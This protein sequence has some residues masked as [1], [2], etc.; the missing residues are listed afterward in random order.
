VVR[1]L[2]LAVDVG[3]VVN[4]DGLMNQIEGGA[5]QA[6]SWTLLES[7]A[8]DNGVVTSSGWD[9]YPILRFDRVPE[10][11]VVV[12]ER[13]GEPVL[14]A[15]EIVHGPVAAAI[16][17]GLYSA[18]GLRARTLPLTRERLIEMVEEQG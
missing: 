17:N 11:E 16:A 7:V 12:I 1:K 5:V 18:I 3:E 8:I 13:S 6:V 14:G 2:T 9:S 15:G 4:M 10:V